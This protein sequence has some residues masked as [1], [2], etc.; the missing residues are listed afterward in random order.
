MIF[1]PVSHKIFTSDFSST[2][3]E[4]CGFVY[5]QKGCAEI[6]V[7]HNHYTL[8]PGDG[9][10]IPSPFSLTL[11]AGKI[12]GVFMT[13]SVS[14]ELPCAVTVKASPKS[15]LRKTLV[16]IIKGM[17]AD[18]YFVAEQLALYCSR[19]ISQ[20]E[21]LVTT[22]NPDYATLAKKFIDENFSKNITLLNVARFCGISKNHLTLCFS[23]KYKTSPWKYFTNKRI[24]KACELLIK[25][26][27]S[28]KEIALAVGFSSSQRFNPAFKK[29]T[30]YTPLEY[31]ACINSPA[32]V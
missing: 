10:I 24:E 6:S 31:R 5:L 14:K 23:E 28:S 3:K 27:L 13:F 30:G 9:L 20:T 26:E 11:S 16:N 22:G 18:C 32:H 17:D 12:Y 8:C 19:F 21:K 15:S 4:L 29:I 7:C 25:T 2:K 1:T